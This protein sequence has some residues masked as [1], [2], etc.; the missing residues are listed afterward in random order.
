MVKVGAGAFFSKKK[1]KVMAKFLCSLVQR[2]SRHLVEI[3]LQNFSL[4]LVDALYRAISL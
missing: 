1:K 3:L 2:Q 4:D